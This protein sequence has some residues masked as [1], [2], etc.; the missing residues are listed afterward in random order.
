MVLEVQNRVYGRR[1]GRPLKGQRAKALEFLLP[2]LE[3]SEDSLRVE[4]GLHPDTLFESPF[5]DYRLEIGF[6]NG[7]HLAALMKKYPETGFLGSEPYING[8]GAFLKAIV[9]RPHDNIRVL[10][11]DALLLVHA[12]KSAC[13]STIYILNPDPWPKKRHHKRRIISQ[14][15]LDAFA[16]VLKPE[17]VLITA[18]DVDDLAE[19]IVMQTTQHAA[20]RW[21]VR[22]KADWETPYEDWIQ[23]HFAQKGE[24]AGRNQRFL[25]FER[26]P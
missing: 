12:L 6:G 8:I 13:L 16:R 25:I 11:D 23:T 2:A 5:S 7:G 14:D 21:T 3:I 18:T 9:D 22:S 15:N 20:F 26:L 19:W 4:R 1:R 10:T 24:A 17:G